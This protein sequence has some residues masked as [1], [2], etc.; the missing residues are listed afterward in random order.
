MKVKLTCFTLSM[1]GTNT[2]GAHSFILQYMQ[3]TMHAI[4]DKREREPRKV[5]NAPFPEPFKIHLDEGLNNYS[6]PNISIIL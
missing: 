6:H 4:W 3:F 5:L 2:S 1:N